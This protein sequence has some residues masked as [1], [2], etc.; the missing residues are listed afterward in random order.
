MIFVD[1]FVP[2]VFPLVKFA[3]IYAASEMYLRR[4]RNITTLFCKNIHKVQDAIKHFEIML[5]SCVSEA[6]LIN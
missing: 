5:S 1:R 4:G 3:I 2:T 6:C